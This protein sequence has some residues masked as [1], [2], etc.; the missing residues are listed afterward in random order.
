[1]SIAGKRLCHHRPVGFAVDAR[2]TACFSLIR[3]NPE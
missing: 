2:R 1:L 3:P